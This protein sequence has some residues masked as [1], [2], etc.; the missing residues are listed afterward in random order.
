MKSVNVR[1]LPA[2]AGGA[3]RRRHPREIA[4]EVRACAP[5]DLGEAF[6]LEI[7]GKVRLFSTYDSEADALRVAKMTRGFGHSVRVLRGKLALT[8][9]RDVRDA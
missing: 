2:F 3:A 5:R 1:L 7:D 8:E 6:A 4:A 9:V